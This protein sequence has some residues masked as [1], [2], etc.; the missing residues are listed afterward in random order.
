MPRKRVFLE[1][2]FVGRTPIFG[3]S[4]FGLLRRASTK[5][6]PDLN[7]YRYVDR[8]LLMIYVIVKKFYYYYCYYFYEYVSTVWR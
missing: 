4:R 5:I 7:D 2:Q 8:S 1:S 3:L 6:H